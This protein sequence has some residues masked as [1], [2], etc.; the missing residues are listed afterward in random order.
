M[1]IKTYVK[2][3]IEIVEPCGKFLGGV[4]TGELDEALY[5]LLSRGVKVVVVN[6]GSLDWMNSSG[7]TIL[8]HHYTKFRD[9][10][11]RLLLANFNKKVEKILVISRLITV[12]QTY[13]SL[14]AA[15]ASLNAENK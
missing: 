11:G 5:R 4:D 6:F 8:V 10:G 15:L 3:G 12:F 7:L 14:D 1:K 2:D 13:E 9:S